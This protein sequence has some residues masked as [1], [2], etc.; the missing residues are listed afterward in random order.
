MP[1]IAGIVGLDRP[2]SSLKRD[3]SSMITSLEYNKDDLV[4]TVN[5]E[6][7][8]IGVVNINDGQAISD[9]YSTADNST[10]CLIDGDIFI[11]GGAMQSVDKEYPVPAESH[12]KKYVPYLYHMHGF[13]F[14]K[15]IKGC[16]NVVILDR[17]EGLIYL[18]NSRFGMRP[19]YYCSLNGYFLFSSELKSILRCS[20]LKRRLNERAVLEYF[21][22]HYPLSGATYVEKVLLLD[23]ATTITVRRSQIELNPYWD[24]DCL[25]HDRLL[26]VKDSLEGAEDLLRKA[27]NIMHMDSK[28]VALPVTGGFDSRTI[29]ALMNR[30]RKDLLLYS[31]GNADSPDVTIPMKI[32]Q[33]L[34]YNYFHINLDDRYSAEF[35]NDCA[36]RTIMYSDGRCS[37]ARAHYLYTSS[38]IGKTAKTIISG[39]CG[40]EL[41]RPVHLTGEVISKN[42]YSLFRGDAAGLSNDLSNSVSSSKYYSRE[43]L[44]R[45]SPYIDDCIAKVQERYDSHYGTNKRFYLFLLKEV[46]RKYFGAEFSIENPYLHNRLPY[47]DYDFVDFIFRTPFCGANYDF[48]VQNPFARIMGQLLYAHIIAANNVQLAKMS[49]SRMYAPS[50]LLSVCGKIKAASAYV[51][52][53]VFSRWKDNYCLL[54]GVSS[55]LS[56]N[57]D[58]INGNEYIDAENILSDGSNGNWQ[59]ERVEFYKAVSF[60][61]WC[62][63]LS[64]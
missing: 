7:Y 12:W 32:A 43:F 60:A 20:L 11:D 25:M 1:G 42:I 38:I 16:F 46:L 3:F 2:V 36:K 13:D 17:R 44:K 19:L 59:R 6:N 58:C 47:L 26:S 45:L 61:F 15:H 8:M 48:F 9:C 52:R 35:Y 57:H 39:N 14:I 40:S 56:K 21:L 10:T 31:F 37:L 62:G 28:K 64:R 63:T 18:A 51:Y 41:L 23:P 55:F 27:V 29:L 30:D 49:T 5:A 4:K 53:K 50:D 54:K 22:F 33:K 24:H 34:S